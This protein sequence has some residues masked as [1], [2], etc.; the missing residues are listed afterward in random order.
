[1]TLPDPLEEQ[2]E[3]IH[4][5]RNTGFPQKRGT[6][7]PEDDMD[8]HCPKCGQYVYKICYECEDEDIA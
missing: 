5:I 1:M 7:V 2:W 3:E 4:E 8:F 6:K